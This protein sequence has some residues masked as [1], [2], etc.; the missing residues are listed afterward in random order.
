MRQSQIGWVVGATMRDGNQ[1]IDGR[2]PLHVALE[3]H[4]N[5]ASADVAL[6]PITFCQVINAHNF[7]S[8]ATTSMVLDGVDSSIAD[9]PAGLAGLMASRNFGCHKFATVWTGAEEHRTKESNVVS[10]LPTVLAHK[11]LISAFAGL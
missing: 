1:V 9:N 11:L 10:N 8:G 7:G 2:C 3:P 6:S 5:T 4:V